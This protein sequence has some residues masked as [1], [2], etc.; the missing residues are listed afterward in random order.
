MD[1]K[2]LTEVECANGSLAGFDDEL[3]VREEMADYIV[4]E[5]LLVDSQGKPLIET[6]RFPPS[7]LWSQSAESTALGTVFCSGVLVGNYANVAAIRHIIAVHPVPV[8]IPFEWTEIPLP[9]LRTVTH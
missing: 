7:V 8:N 1:H 9:V 4:L 6:A 3:A 2:Y 5:S